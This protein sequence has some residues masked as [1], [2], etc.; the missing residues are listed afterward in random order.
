VCFWLATRCPSR[1]EDVVAERLRVDGYYVYLPKARVARPRRGRPNTM[2]LFLG[3][4][5]VDVDQSAGPWQAL[6]RTP[7]VV[8]VV[9]AGEQPSRC[10]DVEIAKLR[11]AEVDGLVT[12]AGPPPPSA[13]KFSAGERVRIRIDAF[14]GKEAAYVRPARQN[15]SVVTVVL[16]SR[17]IEVKVPTYMLAE[18]A[19]VA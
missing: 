7:G 12:L 16:L 2:A 14:A 8:A 11:A 4:L 6:R 13:K 18:L 1:R 3:Y 5:F 19:A 15:M 10:P 9:M 17:V